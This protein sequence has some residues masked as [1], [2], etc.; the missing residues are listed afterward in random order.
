MP[1]TAQ[2][3]RKAWQQLREHEL[4]VAPVD[5]EALA[6]ALD[7]N[8]VFEHMENAVSAM[9]SIEDENAN[10]VVNAGHPENR[11][12]FSIAHELGHFM[13][14]I[15][16][17]KHLFVD[18]N[19]FRNQA[20][21]VG[22]SRQEIEANAYAAALLMPARLIEEELSDEYDTEL[23]IDELAEKFTVSEHAMTI[24]LIKLGYIDA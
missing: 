6:K 15:S 19:F 5:V 16:D 23:Y 1:T 10:V 24:R 11:R 4:D 18:R 17:D 22:E 12:R 20:S 3:E 21:S 9:L 2:I 14:H 7:V 8:V 13:L